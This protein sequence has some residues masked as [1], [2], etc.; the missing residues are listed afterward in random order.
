MLKDKA[1]HEEMNNLRKLIDE[2][3]CEI[4]KRIAYE[5]ETAIRKVT[6][7]TVGWPELDVLAR[8]A[9]FLLKKELGL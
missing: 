5:M 2:S 3:E 7:D 6:E 1:F 9:A 4:T 8:D